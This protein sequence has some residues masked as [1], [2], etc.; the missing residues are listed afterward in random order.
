M[1]EKLLIILNECLEPRVCD[2]RV[3]TEHK[4]TSW[5]LETSRHFPAAVFI[6]SGPTRMNF[7][8]NFRSKLKIACFIF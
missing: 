5:R 2:L 3:F 1:R 6:N 4:H 8:L 7:Y